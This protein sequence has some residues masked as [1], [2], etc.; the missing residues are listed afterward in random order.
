MLIYWA[1]VFQSFLFILFESTKN[2]F[3]LAVILCVAVAGLALEYARRSKND[4]DK[5]VR[6]Q[7]RLEKME[8]QLSELEIVITNQSAQL[9]QL[10]RLIHHNAS[11]PEKPSSTTG[12]SSW[13]ASKKQTEGQAFSIVDTTTVRSSLV[14]IHP[15]DWI[16]QPVTYAIQRTNEYILTPLKQWSSTNR[17]KH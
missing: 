9:L 10:E 1:K 6:Q 15:T 4:S 3:Y 7:E 14:Q 11:P 17:T 5:E 8:K 12:G 2:V 13:F 16:V